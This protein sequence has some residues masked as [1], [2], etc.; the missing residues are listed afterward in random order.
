MAGYPNHSAQPSYPPQSN[1]MYPPQVPGFPSHAPHSQPSYPSQNNPG[2]PPQTP[3][4][5]QNQYSPSSTNSSCYPGQT[6]YP[7]H[8][9][10]PCNNQNYPQHGAYS[11]RIPISTTALSFSDVPTVNKS[12]VCILFVF[13]FWL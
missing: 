8:Q 10:T 13:I 6:P 7:S 4:F 9:A 12:K 11:G 2:Y 3:A 1:S 5:T